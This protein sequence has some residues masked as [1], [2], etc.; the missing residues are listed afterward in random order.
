MRHLR[1]ECGKDP[2][3]TCSVCSFKTKW[4]ANLM[5]HIGCFHSTTVAANALVFLVTEEGRY[6]CVKCGSSYK[7]KKHLKSHMEYECGVERKFECDKCEKKF[8]HRKHLNRHVA[9]KVCQRL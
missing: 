5:K 1:F 8:K 2:S 6:G 9:T 4:K 3:F 7:N